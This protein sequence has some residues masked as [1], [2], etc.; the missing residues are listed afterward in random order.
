MNII[1]LCL[2]LV[3]VFDAIVSAIPVAIHNR[4]IKRGISLSETSTRSHQPYQVTQIIIHKHRSKTTSET[5]K[6]VSPTSTTSTT[7]TTTSTTTTTCPEVTEI[8]TVYDEI[9]EDDARAVSQSSTTSTSPAPS[10]PVAATTPPSGWPLVVVDPPVGPNALNLRF[11]L[12][13]LADGRCVQASSGG[14]KGASL[15]MDTCDASQP[16]QYLIQSGNGLYSFASGEAAVLTT[17]STTKTV[18]LEG[19]TPIDCKNTNESIHAVNGRMVAHVGDQEMCLSVD[20]E[21]KTLV[22]W[23][24]CIQLRAARDLGVDAASS[25][26]FTAAFIDEPMLWPPV[27]GVDGV[28]RVMQIQS[29]D[30]PNFC[31]DTLT[32]GATFGVVKC[33]FSRPGQQ[34]VLGSK[35]AN[36]NNLIQEEKCLSLVGGDG[37]TCNAGSTSGLGL[38]SCTGNPCTLEI[39]L[40]GDG[41]ISAT[42]LG[43]RKCLAITV[44][45]GV[46]V[47]SLVP[48]G[49]V[50]PG[51]F[52]QHF[53]PLVVD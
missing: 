7:L 43:D 48:C 8:V 16:L 18:A 45:A 30:Y 38:E 19:P 21:D 4:V 52:G 44:V 26:T 3:G 29:T 28:S 15:K 20:Y 33:G 25:Q 41:T 9:E 1:L 14:S 5:L 6:S 34:F 2:L 53:A 49:G 10:T 23:E 32:G 50:F 36:R 37:N 39:S 27:D 13:N 47:V 46:H 42:V 35:Y 12:R 24:P 40:D 22:F 17:C 31:L 51:T 11:I